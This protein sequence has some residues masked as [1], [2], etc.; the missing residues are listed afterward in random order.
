MTDALIGISVAPT[1]VVA[2]AM[3]I[4]PRTLNKWHGE[5][6]TLA[7]CVLRRTKHSTWWSV[8]RL[9]DRG[10]LTKPAQAVSP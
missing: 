4:A 6:S 2:E 10:Y 9:R 5:D 3:G 1:S 7:G 8:Q